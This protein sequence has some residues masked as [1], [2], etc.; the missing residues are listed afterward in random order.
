MQVAHLEMIP[1]KT[2]KWMGEWDREDKESN[3]GWI[4]QKDVTMESPTETATTTEP[5]ISTL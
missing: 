1:G 3:K 5:G 4:S 2:V